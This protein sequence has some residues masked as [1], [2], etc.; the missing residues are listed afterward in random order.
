MLVNLM[1]TQGGGESGL[2][3][4]PMYQFVP[5]TKGATMSAVLAT[6]LPRRGSSPVRSVTRLGLR[7]AAILVGLIIVLGLVLPLLAVVYDSRST[8]LWGAYVE[9][10]QSSLFLR[11]LW[12]SIYVSFIVT[13]VTVLLGFPIAYALTLAPRKLK[14]AL[15][16]AFIVPQV[17]SLL[18]RT[19]S[20]M[21]ILG[22]QGP[23]VSLARRLG[24]DVDSYV[25]TFAGVLIVLIHYYLPYVVL[26]S[27]ASM[28][29]IRADQMRAARSLGA[30]RIEAFWSVY[31]P[32]SL[33]GVLTGALFV[34]VITA[35][36]FAI[37]S[38]VGGTG[39][40][41]VSMLVV[42][43]TVTGFSTDPAA[44][45]AQAT[46]LA[47]VVLPIVAFGLS[48]LGIDTLIGLPGSQRKRRGGR[49]GEVVG[50]S[51]FRRVLARWPESDRVT[52]VTVSVATIAGILLTVVPFLYLFLISF[53]P[54]PI[55]AIP[56]QGF[57]TDWYSRV[58]NDPS[59][60][61]VAL[62][63]FR[64]G[65][66]AT[67][68]ALA[69][70][71]YLA[72]LTFR[73][74]RRVGL[75]LMGFACIPL[76]MPAV[77]YGQGY[78]ALFS[79]LEIVGNWFAI[80]IVHSFLILP[81]AYINLLSGFSSYD[82]RL[83]D[84]AASLGASRIRALARVKVPLLRQFVLTGA[85]VAFLFSFDE[86]TVTRFLTGIAF[87]TLPVK[88]YSSAQQN[89]S[90]ELAALGSLLVGGLLILAGIA[91]VLFKKIQVTQKETEEV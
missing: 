36:M 18:V 34:F 66:V 27:Y 20:W 44:P 43:Q 16:V 80:A 68:I 67:L 72:A 39:Q 46:I 63:S 76:V 14:A 28:R 31:A 4:E 5:K 70:G 40:T 48:R 47:L 69:M 86:F 38:L 62:T 58:I 53:Q 30:K 64:I 54:L 71:W 25:G 11:V 83:D 32:Q 90:P 42:Q 22:A 91:A 56:T 65:L 73:S 8:P 1:G 61:Q 60:V 88:F 57:S 59:W 9:Q 49:S 3:V 81:Y 12:R 50:S 13:G 21:A 79:R 10:F 78:F 87:E 26:T 75:F 37:P 84:A 51:I 2:A 29:A 19:Y 55:L 6:D 41:T 82:H 24:S 33:P 7:A 45:A 15:L 35:A 74:S 17:A 52:H 89:L 23:L 77:T 85:L